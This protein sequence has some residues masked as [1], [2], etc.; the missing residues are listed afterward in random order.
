ME[1]DTTILLHY[2]RDSDILNQNRKEHRSKSRASGEETEPK[3]PH[4]NGFIT[5]HLES[6]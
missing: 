6:K 3:I 4:R 1:I 5:Q 2:Q